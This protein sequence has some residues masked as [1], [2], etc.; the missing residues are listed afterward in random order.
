MKLPK[1]RRYT[2]EIE[3]PDL[4]YLAYDLGQETR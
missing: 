4:A 2:I 3:R 1:Q